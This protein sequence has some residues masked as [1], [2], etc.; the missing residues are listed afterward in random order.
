M[1]RLAKSS[2]DR[3]VFEI[4]EVN[5]IIGKISEAMIGVS[6]LPSLAFNP[7][8]FAEAVGISSFDQLHGA[9]EGS[10]HGADDGVQVI[11]HDDEGVRDKFTLR[12]IAV[13]SV[14]QEKRAAFGL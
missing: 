11:G 5:P 1:W 7:K 6:G 4:N 9:F 8:L 13:K 10:F 3:V 2:F 12:P 14:D